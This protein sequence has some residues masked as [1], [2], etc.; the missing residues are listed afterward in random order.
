MQRPYN[1]SAGPAIMPTDVLI[2]AAA[3]M[4][5]WPDYTRITKIVFFHDGSVWLYDTLWA[6]GK[7]PDLRSAIR[8]AMAAEIAK[9]KK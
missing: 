2:Q 6:I 1:F 9:E 7:G 3:E 8:D 5:D 4:L